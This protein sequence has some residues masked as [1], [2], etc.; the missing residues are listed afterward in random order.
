MQDG[1]PMSPPRFSRPSFGR[2][3]CRVRTLTII[4]LKAVRVRT[5]GLK[6]SRR[7]ASHSRTQIT[8]GLEVT[9]ASSFYDS[10]IYIRQCPHYRAARLD[11]DRIW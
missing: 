8:L 2:N 10:I 1:L 11:R 4:G 6:Q 5:R 9:V 7:R 3:G